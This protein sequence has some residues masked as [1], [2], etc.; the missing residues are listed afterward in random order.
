MIY[1]KAQDFCKLPPQKSLVVYF[2]CLSIFFETRDAQIQDLKFITRIWYIEHQL[3]IQHGFGALKAYDQIH[4]RNKFGTWGMRSG[5]LNME[6]WIAILPAC[7]Y[8]EQINSLLA[9]YIGHS[10]WSA[11]SITRPRVCGYDKQTHA[12]RNDNMRLHSL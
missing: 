5:A 11:S 2:L 8:Q 6:F 10:T 7:I 12:P 1:E 3:A 9:R 4:R